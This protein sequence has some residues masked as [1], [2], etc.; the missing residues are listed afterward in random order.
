MLFNR[1]YLPWFAL[2]ALGAGLA[3]YGIARGRG[4]AA[5]AG[6]AAF[7]VGTWRINAELA[8]AEKAQAKLEQRVFSAIDVT[9]V[10]RMIGS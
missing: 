8:A 9:P 1:R 4:I 10:G 7:G 5:L 6:S 3:T 2:Q